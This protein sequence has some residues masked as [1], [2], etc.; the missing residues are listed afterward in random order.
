MSELI[1]KFCSFCG[2]E[3]LEYDVVEQQREYLNRVVL[4]NM[5]TIFS[6]KCRMCYRRAIVT[7]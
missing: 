6:V 4:I 5:K 2:A 7:A 3:N 1:P